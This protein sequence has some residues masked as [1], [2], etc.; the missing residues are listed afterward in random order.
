MQFGG[1][2]YFALLKKETSAQEWLALGQN[3]QFELAGVIYE[4]HE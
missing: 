2:E 1:N 3:V 4:I